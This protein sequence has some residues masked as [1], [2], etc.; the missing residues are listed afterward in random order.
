[1]P[2][3]STR[4]N[5]SAALAPAPKKQSKNTPSGGRGDARK[6]ELAKLLFTRNEFTQKV[7]AERV[8]V[9]EKTLGNWIKEGMWQDIKKSLLLT[10]DEQLRLFYDQLSN[11]NNAINKR[12]VDNRYPDSKEANTQKLIAA[13]IRDLEV[14]TNVSQII[15]V[16][17]EFLS[18][19][20]E[21][22]KEHQE[23]NNTLTRH[24]DAFIK[25]RLKRK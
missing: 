18:W 7:V 14:E 15:Q 17:K 9:T 24:F 19:I 2:V 4:K 23:F 10:K 6:K 25:E 20:P 13:S 11:L 12:P 3:K 5:A 1:M 22:T 8:G 21:E 16:A